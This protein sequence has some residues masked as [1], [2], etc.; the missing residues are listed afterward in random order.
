[1]QV[2]GGTDAT[3][4]STSTGACAR[5]GHKH[6]DE[7][8]I[9]PEA[10]EAEASTATPTPDASPAG[11]LGVREAMTS[12][13]GEASLALLSHDG[14]VSKAALTQ[15]PRPAFTQTQQ[16]AKAGAEV[17]ES[18][19][20]LHAAE[21]APA[22]KEEL[23]ASPWPRQDAW[24]ADVVL[25]DDEAQRANFLNAP[26]SRSGGPAA[27][28]GSPNYGGSCLGIGSGADWLGLPPE[29][30]QHQQGRRQ[31]AWHG[32]P[33]PSWQ[34]MDGQF[35]GGAA[36]YMQDQF[37]HCGMPAI[38]RSAAWDH[39]A[40]GAGGYVGMDGGD[41][42]GAWSRRPGSG[43]M[44]V[45]QTQGA[46][47]PPGLAQMGAP[48]FVPLRS[49]HMQDHG[50]R[51]DVDSRAYAAAFQDIWG[52]G[53]GCGGLVQSSS[54]MS[55]FGEGWGSAK[56]HKSAEGVGVLSQDDHVFSKTEGERQQRVD[57]KGA[58]Y[59]LAQIC[60]I[61]DTSLRCGGTHRYHCAFMDGE[62]GPA[63]GAGFTFDSR[64]RR[65]SM[66]QVVAVFINRRGTVCLRRGKNVSK[67]PVQLPQLIIGSQLILIMNLDMLTAHFEVCDSSGHVM[68]SAD[69][70]LQSLSSGN[71]ADSD[72]RSGF[73]CAVVTNTVVVGLH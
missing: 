70:G 60:M 25:N 39:G 58:C 15:R 45:E 33:P 63:D 13:Q 17:S 41:W 14:V 21:W 64:L 18:A 6:F 3:T 50:P 71:A 57:K 1:M 12:T 52:A 24:N 59:E 65:R 5:E 61:F 68:G 4:I 34:G 30:E 67:L 56:W 66:Q 32:G 47:I 51:A 8:V 19:L 36:P 54:V 72:L 28:A 2:T 20:A 69:V 11:A 38:A 48:R 42:A 10:P 40:A 7:I 44:H 53:K 73:F 16:P 29:M 26:L 22:K 43:P 49:H 23:T 37:D 62:L 31:P 46:I 35:R 55:G 27:E 9:M